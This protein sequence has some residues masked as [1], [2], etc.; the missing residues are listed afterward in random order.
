MAQKQMPN[1]LNNLVNLPFDEQH[2]LVHQ[3]E[4]PWET[5]TSSIAVEWWIK[6]ETC[7]YILKCNSA[8]FIQKDHIETNH[9]RSCKTRLLAIQ[10]KR[11]TKRQVHTVQP[12]KWDIY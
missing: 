3:A 5:A 9:M 2:Q 1:S 10:L 8:L 4:S 6:Y 12:F 11:L 7:I